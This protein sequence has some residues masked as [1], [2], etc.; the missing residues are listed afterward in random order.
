MQPKPTIRDL[1]ADRARRGFVGRERELALLNTLLGDDDRWY[2]TCGVCPA[3]A[4]L[5]FWTCSL[6]Q[7]APGAPPSCILTGTQ[8]RRRKQ[9]FAMSLASALSGSPQDSSPGGAGDRVVLAIDAYEDLRLLDT[10]LRQV[11]VPSLPGNVP[12]C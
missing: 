6:P 3:L 12:G 2:C 7:R 1:L 11:L 10:W 9:V 5:A 4:S 8:S